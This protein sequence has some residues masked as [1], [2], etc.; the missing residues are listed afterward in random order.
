MIKKRNTCANKENCQW[1]NAVSQNQSKDL[2]EHKILFF[3]FEVENAQIYNVFLASRCWAYFSRERFGLQQ[4][5]VSDL[6]SP[7]NTLSSIATQSA[8]RF[9]IKKKTVLVE[10]MS[11]EVF[12]KYVN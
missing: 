1:E 5:E 7:T 9:S 6:E 8:W 4:G 11:N 3:P 10:T 12:T 2:D